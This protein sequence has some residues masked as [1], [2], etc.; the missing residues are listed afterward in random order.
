LLFKIS[1]QDITLKTIKDNTPKKV[2][3]AAS[4][5]VKLLV[6]HNNKHPAKT[7]HKYYIAII[8]IFNISLMITNNY[9]NYI[10]IYV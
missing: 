1:S 8:I 4:I 3:K 7:I 6:I 5:P 10:Y 9:K 2:T